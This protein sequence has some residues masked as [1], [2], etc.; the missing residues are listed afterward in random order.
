MQLVIGADLEAEALLAARAGQGG[1]GLSVPHTPLMMLAIVALSFVL[2]QLVGVPL[3][4]GGTL[5]TDPALVPAV[6]LLAAR[7][8]TA[9]LLP[10]LAA[11]Q[12][13]L[14]VADTLD[15][16]GVYDDQARV[17]RVAASLRGAGQ[18]TLTTLLAHEATHAQG[19]L[20]GTVAQEEATESIV[21][22]C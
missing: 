6:Q 10:T 14:E 19:D 3:P 9:P 2:A 11:G 15:A 17:I 4:A 13:R 21:A 20:G 22:A 1:G 7:A 16:W 5:A 18:R 12:V 8:D